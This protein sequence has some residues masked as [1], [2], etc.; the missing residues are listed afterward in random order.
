MP[1]RKSPLATKNLL[2]DTD[3][4]RR[5]PFNPSVPSRCGSPLLLLTCALLMT[6]SHSEGQMC[7]SPQPFMLVA[8]KSKKK[9]N[10]KKGGG[11][12]QAVS[13]ASLLGP[14]TGGGGGYSGNGTAAS[15]AGG[16]RVPAQTIP[17]GVVAVPVPEHGVLKIAEGQNAFLWLC[18]RPV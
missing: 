11:R 18:A 16:V 17:R 7:G 10:K 2:E 6:S 5:P 15:A 12:G 1:V 14:G 13:L 4:L 8:T 9:K 3:G